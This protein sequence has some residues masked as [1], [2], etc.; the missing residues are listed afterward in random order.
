MQVTEHMN[1]TVEEYQQHC[2]QYD[3]FCT[4]CEEWTVGGVEPDAENYTCEMC[5]EATVFGCEQ[6]LIMGCLEIDDG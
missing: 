6:L 3:G 2:D 4:S 1:L 5:D